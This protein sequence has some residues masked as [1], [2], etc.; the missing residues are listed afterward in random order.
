MR[1]RLVALAI[2]LVLIEAA[3]SGQVAW[4]D[5]SPHSVSFVGIEQGV[6]LEVLDWGGQGVPMILLAGLGNTAHVF[7]QFALH[8]TDRFHVIGITRRGFGASAH[9]E[10]GYDMGTLANDIR[11]ANPYVGFQYAID[12]RRMSDTE[13]DLSVYVIDSLGRR[14]EVG[15]RK[16]VVLNNT[17]TK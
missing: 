13:H 9:P 4:T 12:T 15:R 2:S 10:S 6:A 5:P 1:F 16:F 14:S 3:M 17:S 8:F 11:V 7:D